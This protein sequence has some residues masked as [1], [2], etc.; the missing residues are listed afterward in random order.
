MWLQVRL[1]ELAIYGEDRVAVQAMRL[2]LDS[3]P[4]QVGLH[5]GLEGLTIEELGEVY[6]RVQGWL[7]TVAKDARGSDGD[8]AD[9]TALDSEENVGWLF[10]LDDARLPTA[11][12]PSGDGQNGDV[13]HQ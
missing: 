12:V 11:T 3:P 8:S 6:E 13:D 4:E 1:L 2:L 7:D 9:V 5:E 10:A